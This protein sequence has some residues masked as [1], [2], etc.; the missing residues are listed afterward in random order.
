[1]ILKGVELREITNISSNKRNGGKFER[2]N[3]WEIAEE[4]DESQEKAMKEKRELNLQLESCQKAMEAIQK[5]NKRLEKEILEVLEELKGAKGTSERLIEENNRLM[6]EY[7]DLLRSKAHLEKLYDDIVKELSNTEHSLN[8]W[9]QN[10]AKLQSEKNQLAIQN[11]SLISEIQTLKLTI[12]ENE[13]E[14][15][16]HYQNLLEKLETSNNQSTKTFELDYA[17]ISVSFTEDKKSALVYANENLIQVLQLEEAHQAVSLAR[18]IEVEGREFHLG[19]ECSSSEK[20]R[21]SSHSGSAWESARK[22]M[23]SPKYQVQPFDFNQIKKQV[24]KKEEEENVIVSERN[25]TQG[26]TETWEDK[27]G[28]WILE[29]HGEEIEG[30]EDQSKIERIEVDYE[31]TD[32]EDDEEL[33]ET[34][35]SHPKG[36]QTPEKVGFLVGL[37]LRMNSLESWRMDW[38][39]KE[40]KRQ[41]EA[42]S[43]K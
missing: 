42:C 3:T 33:G 7:A 41:V 27:P 13:E 4:L 36:S 24:P 43:K 20:Q 26:T 16:E 14:Y 32:G 18:E 25:E 22:P 35:Y 21:N 19:A 11:S 1:M 6:G 2:M 37:L 31:N 23:I 12:Q 34:S 15:K 8:V 5:E 29:T 38:R 9:K 10:H 28:L 17:N 39:I 40:A 30:L